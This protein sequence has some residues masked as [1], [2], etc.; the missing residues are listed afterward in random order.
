MNYR[1]L[2]IVLLVT[3]I[4]IG[5]PFGIPLQEAAADGLRVDDRSDSRQDRRGDRR[6]NTGDG[7]EDRQEFREGRPDS[8]GEGPDARV[9]N[10]ED[11]R[12]DRQDRTVDRMEDRGEGSTSPFSWAACGLNKRFAD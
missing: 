1:I 7:V 3:L 9:D 2:G 6:E 12:D 11:K 8:V 10:R 5:G 4:S